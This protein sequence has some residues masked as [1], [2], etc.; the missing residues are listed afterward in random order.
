M[1]KFP[2]MNWSTSNV[3]DEFKLF[4]QRTELCFLD[5]NIV[6]PI[7]QATKIKI[8]VGNEG[9]RKI[10]ASGLSTDDQNNPAKLWNLFEDQLK[11]KVN[12]RIHRLELM[13]YRQKPGESIDEFVNR[14]RSK[15]VECDFKADELCERLVELVIASTPIEAFQKDLLDQPKGF[16]AD[17]LIETGRKYEAIMAGRQCLQTL[18]NDTNIGAISPASKKRCGNCGLSHPPKRC[19]AYKDYCKACGTIGHWAKMCRKTKHESK[20]QP[21]HTGGSTTQQKGR[22]RSRNRRFRNRSTYRGKDRDRSPSQRGWNKSVDAVIEGNPHERPWQEQED[23]VEVSFHSIGSKDTK[24]AFVDVE[25]VCPKR[26]GRATLSLKVDTGAG[27][28]VL[29]LR[30]LKD[31]YPQTWRQMITP[32]SAQLSAYNGTQITCLGSITLGCR[33]KQSPWS[34]QLLYI[35]DA[36]GP[37]ILGLPGCQTLGVVTINEIRD[38]PGRSLQD[39]HPIKSIK[40][41]QELYPH[42]FDTIGNFKGEAI[43]YLKEDAT[44]SIDPP[45][46]CS[47]HIRDKLKAEL[48]KMEQEGVIRKVQHYTEWCS[49]LTT[50]VKKD[51]SLRVCLDPKRLNNALRRCPHKIPTLEELNPAFSGAKFFSKLDA[52][53]GYWSVHLEKKSQELT[54]F[55]TPFGRYCFQRL[56]FGLSVSQDIFQERMDHI[57]AQVPGCVGIADDIAVFSQTEAEHDHNLLQLMETARREGLVFNSTKCHIKTDHIEFFGSVYTADGIRPDPKKVEDVRQM[58]TPQDK[59]DLQRSLG[60]FTYLAPYIPNYAE[61]S[62]IL[63]DLLKK[64]VPFLWQEDHQ[65]AFDDLKQAITSESCLKYFNPQEET[66]VEVDASQ[67][68]LGACLLQGGIPVA[69]ASKSLSPAQANYSNIEREA[70]G[71][72]FGITRFHTYLFGRTFTVET[73]HKPLEMIWKKPLASAP[74]RLQRL[75][76]KIQGYDCQADLITKEDFSGSCGTAS[77]VNTALRLAIKEKLT[78]SINQNPECVARVPVDPLVFEEV[79]APCKNT[80]DRNLLNE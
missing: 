46:K 80:Q 25:I 66:T 26:T 9:L 52:K 10:N 57:I 77:D 24:E 15:A 51:G 23:N 76:I 14:C 1:A 79:F 38:I 40:D 3:A 48:D 21:R 17:K 74:P 65:H 67:K 54:T 37:A 29:P 32:T 7:K 20:T 33:Y 16:N 72:V 42:Q 73:D 69:F 43:L 56:P 58:P 53:S 12:F 59:D 34:Q 28:N 55:R 62:S 41:L 61:R 47:V 5:H 39:S 50:S 64:D 60:F 71:L 13:R 75:L 45:R 19:P 36:A 78:I 63:R 30:I 68:G 31:M 70:L 6:D 2:E 35:T 8:A 27:G 11:V 49:S 4:R 22:N 18:D 44:P